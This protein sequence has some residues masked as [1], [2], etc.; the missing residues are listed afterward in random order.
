[1]DDFGFTINTLLCLT[2]MVCKLFILHNLE[3]GSEKLNKLHRWENVQSRNQMITRHIITN[4]I[5]FKLSILCTYSSCH[6]ILQLPRNV[7]PN[8]SQSI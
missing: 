2:V 1:M 4:T 6:Y 7:S 5:L 3:W 8:F